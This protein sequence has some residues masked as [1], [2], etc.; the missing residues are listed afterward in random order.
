MAKK[1]EEGLKYLQV[2]LPAGQKRGKMTKLS[3]SGINYRNTKDSG[4]IS[5]ELNISTISA[6]HLTPSEKR[7]TTVDLLSEYGNMS[8][9]IK[10]NNDCRYYDMYAYDNTLVCCAIRDLKN[11]TFSDG[12]TPADYYE[13]LYCVIDSENKI[14]KTGR[15]TISAEATGEPGNKIQMFTSF[16][17][18]ANIATISNS[19]GLI[20]FPAKLS[21]SFDDVVVVN[22]HF[23]ETTDAGSRQTQVTAWLK[24]YGSRTA[25]MYF[26]CLAEHSD[27]SYGY[28]GPWI[29]YSGKGTGGKSSHWNSYTEYQMKEANIA[30]VPSLRHICIAH[31]RLFGI[32]DSCVYASGYN[33]YANWNFDTADEYS[34]E[35]AW[36]SSV[37]SNNDGENVGIVGYGGG[38]FVFKKDSTYEITNTKNPFRIREVF[39][40][41]ALCQRAIQVVG[42]Y[43]IFV[44]ADAI[45]LYNG[46]TLKDIG[47]KLNADKFYSAVT[48]SDGRRLYLYCQ[49]DKK[50]KNFFVYDT[51]TG[52]W[53]EED[54]AVEFEGFAK[55]NNGMF[56]IDKDFKLYKLDTGDYS[57]H[58]MTE[59]DLSCN[60]TVD[61]KHI[62]KVQMLADIA[63]GSEICAYVLYDDEVFNKNTS[64]LI[65]KHKNE[66]TSSIKIPIRTVPRKTANYGFKIHIEGYGYSKIYQMEI[67]ISEG[68][69]KYVSG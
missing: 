8:A 42:S 45:M 52:I 66:G 44:S 30:N 64:H 41:G 50:E 51:Y 56:G 68:G 10:F 46:T 37:Q 61:I 60:S 34:A 26:K 65:F 47:Y 25:Q 33:D 17:N 43:L 22:K 57:H 49:T 32:S 21:I 5:A 3:W 67:L 54:N 20:F 48:G 4:E 9:N 2:P 58:W 62:N 39:K 53:A 12:T 35:N 6:P 69:E 27:V 28:N 15:K 31:Q 24:D 59:T 14:I 40:K 7:Q 23:D 36:M 38:V 55:N 63:P 13:Y 1:K 11:G 19:K 29:K 16:Q 18:Y